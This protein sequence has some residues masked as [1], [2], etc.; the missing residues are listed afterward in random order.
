[1]TAAR[2]TGSRRRCVPG[3]GSRRWLLRVAFS[4]VTAI[5][6]RLSCLRD[7][8]FQHLRLR[9]PARIPRASRVFIP[10]TSVLLPRERIAITTVHHP[11]R[12]GRNGK[13]N[14][15]FNL[16]LG[17]RTTPCS[18]LFFI[19][20][21]F[22]FYS[23]RAHDTVRLKAKRMANSLP[24]RVSNSSGLAR[25]E[26]DQPELDRA[27]FGES[28]LHASA[29]ATVPRALP[30]KR[31]FNSY[32]L[33]GCSRSR[34]PRP[35]LTHSSSL[36]SYY[37]FRFLFFLLILLSTCSSTRPRSFHRSGRSVLHSSGA[38]I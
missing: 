8:G 3:I 16:A 11:R 9:V 18:T 21:C 20:L 31:L 17:P 6:S 29:H 14:G 34:R 2:T 12:L 38:G 15:P 5:A 25:S 13:A 10:F 1:M 24:R 36:L 37:F 26:G 35:P 27:S 32:V 7:H 30:P 33:Q 28:F 22:F 23:A 4:R 19:F